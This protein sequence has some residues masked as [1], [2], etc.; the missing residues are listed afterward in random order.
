MQV[1][2]ILNYGLAKV[3]DLMIKHVMKPAVSN[4]SMNVFVEELSQDDVDKPQAILSLIPSSD[5]EVSRISFNFRSSFSLNIS[6][7]KSHSIY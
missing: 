7:L 5:A 1:V 2:G 3:A 4:G 6:I